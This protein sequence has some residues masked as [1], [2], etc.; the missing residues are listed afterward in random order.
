MLIGKD[1]V[2]NIHASGEKQRSNTIKVREIVNPVK[3][4]DFSQRKNSAG[5]SSSCKTQP[6]SVNPRTIFQQIRT[7]NIANVEHSLNNFICST[8]KKFS[9]NCNLC[10]RQEENIEEI[11]VSTDSANESQANM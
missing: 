11:N 5:L 2:I 8:R 1:A 6:S 10:D 7:T 4:A 3:I 9:V